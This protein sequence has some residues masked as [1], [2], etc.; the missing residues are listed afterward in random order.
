MK[1]ILLIANLL[2]FTYLGN[3]QT[4]QAVGLTDTI[5]AKAT[6]FEVTYHV[7][8][9]NGSGSNINVHVYRNDFGVLG[10]TVNYYCWGINCFPPT[11]SLST[12][13]VQISPGAEDHSFVSYYEPNQKE[14]I[15]TIEYCFF[16][17]AGS[18]DSLC[19]NLS[20]KT[21]P[22]P[23]SVAES[24]QEQKIAKLFPNPAAD[25]VYLSYN[26]TEKGNAFIEIYDLVGKLV[27]KMSI[28]AGNQRFVFPVSQLEKGIYLVSMVSNGET[29]DTQKLIVNR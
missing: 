13:P 24:A 15:S 2:V 16:D 12:D 27:S 28:N 7:P 20:F 5:T 22:P 25:L 26:L 23:A 19:F 3:A 14:G 6:E 1:R 8:I 17:I 11:T 10:S 18:N 9:K 21:V 29:I 4:I